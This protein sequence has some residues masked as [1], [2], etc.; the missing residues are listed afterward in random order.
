[1]S[2]SRAKVVYWTG[3]LLV[4]AS[5]LAWF[6]WPSKVELSPD[7]YDVAIALYRV[8]N[9]RDEDGLEQ[10][11]QKLDD[12]SAAAAP[13]DTGLAHLQSIIDEAEAGQWKAAMMQTRTALADQ[14]REL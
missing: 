2:E 4:A 10:V 13:G 5:V 9:Q 1:M 11:Q 12:L 3:G 8:C 6:L 7:T 14:T